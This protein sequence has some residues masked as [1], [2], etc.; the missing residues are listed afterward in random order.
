MSHGLF[1]YKDAE[2]YLVEDEEGN[3]LK[4]AKSSQTI[5]RYVQKVAEDNLAK[6]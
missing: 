4:K 2:Y 5:S 6:S 1:Q 3:I